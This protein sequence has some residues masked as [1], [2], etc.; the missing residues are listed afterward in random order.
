M[1]DLLGG[2]GRR[3]GQRTEVLSLAT[4]VLQE[5]HGTWAGTMEGDGNGLAEAEASGTPMFF[6]CI[7]DR[8]AVVEVWTFR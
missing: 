2:L 1:P 7:S 8:N 3:C 6:D 5:F 4:T